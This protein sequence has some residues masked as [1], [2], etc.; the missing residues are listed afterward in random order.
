MKNKWWYLVVA[1]AAFA[2]GMK[3][4]EHVVNRW[5]GNTDSELRAAARRVTEQVAAREVVVHHVGTL[6]TGEE[7]L[8]EFAARQADRCFAANLLVCEVARTHGASREMSG[9]LLSWCTVKVEQERRAR[10]A[11]TPPDPYA[12]DAT[13]R[14]AATHLQFR[15]F[16][17]L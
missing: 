12:E 17:T 9:V 2:A 8:D 7:T 11:G 15:L 4:E 5:V 6:A 16:H 3:A 13:N 1:V 14:P 10:A